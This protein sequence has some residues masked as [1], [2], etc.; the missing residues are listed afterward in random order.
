MATGVLTTK[1]RCMIGELEADTV[2]MRT[3]S[4]EVGLFQV[5]RYTTV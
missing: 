4:A 3:F 1:G 2:L 5:S